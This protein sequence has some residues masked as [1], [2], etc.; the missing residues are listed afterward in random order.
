[1]DQI[2]QNIVWRTIQNDAEFSVCLRLC[3]LMLLS[4]FFSWTVHSCHW[5]TKDKA[6]ESAQWQLGEEGIFH[7]GL[8]FKE[9][10]TQSMCWAVEHLLQHIWNML[11]S[12]ARVLTDKRMFN[13]HP[14][15]LPVFQASPRNKTDLDSSE[16]SQNCGRISEWPLI[17]TYF[18]T[19][20]IIIIFRG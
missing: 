14:V 9:K 13:Q 7:G 6:P 10:R 1:M 11:L 18:F 17:A 2:R 15:L 4:E 3:G 19:W 5:H 12:V 20:I 8:V 16:G